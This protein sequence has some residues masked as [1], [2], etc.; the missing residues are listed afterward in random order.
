MSLSLSQISI[1]LN[2]IRLLRVIGFCTA[3]GMCIT[4]QCSYVAGVLVS[5]LSLLALARLLFGSLSGVSP[6]SYYRWRVLAGSPLILVPRFTRLF[7]MS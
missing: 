3:P 1:S 5:L 6:R 7:G 4:P 2:W